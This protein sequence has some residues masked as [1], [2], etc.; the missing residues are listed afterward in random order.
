MNF[1]LIGDSMCTEGW[2]NLLRVMIMNGLPGLAV[3]IF[4]IVIAVIVGFEAGRWWAEAMRGSFEARLAW[5]RRKMYRQQRKKRKPVRG[6][7]HDPH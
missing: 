5:R 1:S 2:V 4:I 7:A 3:V 6:N